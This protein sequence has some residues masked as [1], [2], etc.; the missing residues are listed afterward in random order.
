MTA[1]DP[2]SEDV[3]TN[4]RF[5]QPLLRIPVLY[6]VLISN[7]LII[8][9]GATIGTWLATRLQTSP[10]PIILVIFVTV[11]WLISVV[12]NS[13]FSKKATIL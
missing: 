2:K 13:R 3:T 9:A 8:F 1:S 11:G 12:L 4:N 5:L 7:S 10:Y 6:R